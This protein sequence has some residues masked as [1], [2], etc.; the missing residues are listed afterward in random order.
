MPNLNL[1][2]LAQKRKYDSIQSGI[3]AVGLYSGRIMNVYEDTLTADVYIY[4]LS[5]TLANVR[6]SSAFMLTN[7]GDIS[8]PIAGTEA[9]VAST[10]DTSGAFIVAYKPQYGYQK[11]EYFNNAIMQGEMQSCSQEQAFNKKDVCGNNI[12][13]SGNADFS[14]LGQGFE[15]YA[16]TNES[17]GYSHDFSVYNRK[18]IAKEYSYDDINDENT[19]EILNTSARL[20]ADLFDTNSIFDIL[21]SSNM[22]RDFIKKRSLIEKAQ[23]KLK[24]YLSSEDTDKLT[25]NSD[26]VHIS[27]NKISY[28]IIN[29]F[30]AAQTVISDDETQVVQ[31]DESGNVL[32]T[33][34]HSDNLIT[35][36]LTGPNIKPIKKTITISDNNVKEEIAWLTGECS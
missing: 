36:V 20:V 14:M 3:S 15:S 10:S 24:S 22:E 9:V 33:T 28:E 27:G 35:Q 4:V 32:S 19:T 11:D 17:H 13:A 16:K 25:I 29:G 31:T 2:S 23:Q 18:S 34:I 6:I 1:A 8:M 5:K 12:S 26:G 7:G 21:N 30:V